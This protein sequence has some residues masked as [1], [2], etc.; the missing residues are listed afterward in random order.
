MTEEEKAAQKARPIATNP[1]PGTPWYA[2]HITDHISPLLYCNSSNAFFF[3]PLISVYVLNQVCGMDGWWSR[4]LLQPDNAAV[5]VGPARGAGWSSWRRQAHPGA[6]AQERPGG[7]QEDRCGPTHVHIQ[8]VV[9]T[10]KTIILMIVNDEIYWD[11]TLHAAVCV[12]FIY[13]ASVCS[14]TGVNKE[15]PE[16]AIATEEN[17]DEE[18][19]KAK[20]RK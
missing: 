10:L 7:W 18:P 1:I 8:S 16:L 19:T 17:Q 3:C 15:E 14:Y 9:M 2:H 20:K 6:A 5:H 11:F 4:V 13:F 12:V